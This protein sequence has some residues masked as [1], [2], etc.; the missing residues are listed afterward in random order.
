[1]T[2]IRLQLEHVSVGYDGRTVVEGINLAA[3]RGTCLAL[4]GPN[5]SGK[6][7][8]MRAIAG[9]HMPTQG[10]IRIDGQPLHPAQ[11]W[12]G[13]LPGLALPPEELPGF[14][15]VRQCLDIYAAAHGLAAVPEADRDLAAA[16]GLMDHADTLVRNASLGTRQKLAVVLALM[17][18]PSVLLLD[19]VFSGLDF[20]SVLVLRE[21]LR[22]LVQHGG[23]TVVL[24]THSLD[25]ALRCCDEL[26]L[27]D[28]GRLVGRWELSRFA[29]GNGL[30]DLE[31]ELAR[32]T[33]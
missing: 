28:S 17:T 10:S 23:M 8:L 21:H 2:A 31:R 24:A 25:T 13:V 16:L 1:M 7:T 14:L 15:T 6:T 33:E 4:V 18:Q 5:A 9:R 29:G 12:R 32:A 22:K 20:A 26:V 19:E 3:G 30:A 27:L 11:S